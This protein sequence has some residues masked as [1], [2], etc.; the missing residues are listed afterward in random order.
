MPIKSDFIDY[1]PLGNPRRS[2]ALESEEFWVRKS[3]ARDAG[4]EQVSDVKEGRRA[5]VVFGKNPRV[6]SLLK[7]EETGRAPLVQT[8]LRRGHAVS[9]IGLFL[10]TMLVFVRPYELS[11]WLALMPRI[12]LI[13]AIATLLVFIPTQL[14]LENRLT[15][16]TREVN[17]VLLLLLLCLIS[18]PLAT[19]KL[20]AWNGFVD[21][22]KVVVMF[23]VMVNVTRT[24][25]RLKALLVLIL[26]VSVALSVAAIKDYQ[27]G[28]LALGG[29]RIEGMIGGLFDNPNDLALHLVTLFPISIGLALGSRGL[30]AKLVYFATAF[31][32]LGGTVVT[33]SR[34][35]FLGLI[36]VFGTLAWTLGRKNRS[37]VAVAMI[38]LI[39]LFLM[40][41]P[42]AYRER[43]RTTDDE[44][45][46]A[47]TAELKR[48]IFLAVRH[49]VFGIGMGNFIVYSDTE[50]S[51][52]NAYTQVASEL[53]LTAGVV[54]VLFLL[55]ALK[56]VR[57]MP[58]PKEVDKK[59]RALPYLA[60]GL[61]AGLIGYMVTSFFA[62]V[63][64][65][66]YA[67]YL[68]GYAVCVSR[69]YENSL[70]TGKS[71]F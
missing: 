26:L 40:L 16:R 51:T 44:S 19:D 64:Y 33:F 2:K 3:I 35:G 49:P 54:Y 46:T 21:Y 62:S 11:P 41:A 1:E 58:N 45:A 57:Q 5:E 71:R 34:G 32:L 48:S 8:A 27:A 31:I 39:T 43:L 12:A 65:L 18:V 47:R 30:A 60:I 63:A 25:K 50:H 38:L 68:V 28:N 55:A 22:S 29:K 13:T 15:V 6:D 36:F 17:L 70:I 56:R 14:G 20:L 37:L 67:Y 69:L 52:H 24:E 23:V 61:Q 10:F 7:A 59:K 66:W 42:G 53:G 4:P 9:F